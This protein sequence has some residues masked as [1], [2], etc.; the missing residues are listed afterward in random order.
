MQRRKNEY[1]PED[2]KK[3][4]KKLSKRLLFLGILTLLLIITGSVFAY[5]RHE[6]S[7]HK[8]TYHAL[9]VNAEKDIKRAKI[10]EKSS[11]IQKATLAIKKLNS[12]DKKLFTAQISEINNIINLKNAIASVNTAYKTQLKVD[13]TTAQK[14]IQKLKTNDKKTLS[15]KINNLT[16]GLSDITTATSAIE[17]AEKDKSSA[18]EKVSQMKKAAEAQPMDFNAIKNGDYSSLEGTWKTIAFSSNNYDGKGIQWTPDNSNSINQLLISKNKIT[19]FISLSKNQLSESNGSGT[20]SFN[21]Q[22]GSLSAEA[23]VGAIEDSISFYPAGIDITFSLNNGVIDDTSKNRILIRSSNMDSGS[24]FVQTSKISST[25]F[26]ISDV[27]QATIDTDIKTAQNDINKLTQDWENSKKVTLQNRLNTL[28]ASQSMNLSQIE[29]GNYNTIQGIWKDKNGDT[30]NVSGNKINWTSSTENTTIS[31]LTLINSEIV[32]ATR[33]TNAVQLKKDYN[34]T[35]N[36]NN[37]IS[38]GLDM[39]VKIDNASGIG[40]YFI[41]IDYLPADCVPNTGFFSYD[42][43][44]GNTQKDRIIAW[45]GQNGPGPVYYKQ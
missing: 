29:T 20:V 45:S 13:I 21:N 28:I 23:P 15:Q 2:V 39:G 17:K 38:G 16:T 27:E 40:G 41:E 34:K 14:N 33:K 4:N 5:Q 19:S 42:G 18:Y 22:K 43:S 8:A 10:T 1:F 3:N 26:S 12:N 37:T 35:P 7:L 11:D 6:I 36:Y 32:Q 25:S 44:S 31:G 24:I 30:F 9:K